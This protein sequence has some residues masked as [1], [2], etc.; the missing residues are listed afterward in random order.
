MARKICPAC[1]KLNAG[2]AT[3]CRCGHEFA[4]STIVERQRT[5]KRCPSCQ[6]PQPRLLEICGCGH[7]FAEIRELREFARGACS[8]RMVLRR[9]RCNGALVMYRDHDR[10]LGNVADRG[11][12]RRHAHVSRILDSRRRTLATARRSSGGRYVAERQGPA[13]DRAARAERLRGGTDGAMGKADRRQGNARA[14]AKAD[15]RRRVALRVLQGCDEAGARPRRAR[16]EGCH[17]VL[18]RGLLVLLLLRGA[19]VARRRSER[20]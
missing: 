16:L 7:E 17:A 15:E 8:H 9:A 19:G 20:M 5:T 13:L 1:K 11:V 10:D 6:L 4:A 3:Q 14:L 18:H 2:S 12:R